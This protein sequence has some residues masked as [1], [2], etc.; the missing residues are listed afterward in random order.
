MD[1]RGPAAR[2]QA[3]QLDK[4]RFDLEW[5]IPLEPGLST[6]VGAYDLECVLP[7]AIDSETTPARPACED[8]TP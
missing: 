6:H 3:A 4:K 2:Q 7:H 8:G 5:A 1:E